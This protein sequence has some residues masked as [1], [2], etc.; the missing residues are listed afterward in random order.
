MTYNQDLE[1]T[2]SDNH[3]NVFYQGRKDKLNVKEQNF[4]IDGEVRIR[5]KYDRKKDQSTIITKEAG[6]EKVKEI[7]SG[8]ILLLLNTNSGN[9]EYG[10]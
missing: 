2:P 6:M 9:L 5:I 4:E 3:Y 7:K 8:L 10:Y 1:V